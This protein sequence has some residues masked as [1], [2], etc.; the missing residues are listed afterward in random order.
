MRVIELAALPGAGKTRVCAELAAR[1][2]PGHLSWVGRHRRL[3]RR[4]Q[5]PW[6][7]LPVALLRYRSVL[8]VLRAHPSR[9]ALRDALRALPVHLAEML[10]FGLECRLRRR[11][12]ILDEGF[13]QRGIGLWLRADPDQRS[14]LWEAWLACAPREHT[15]LVLSCSPDEALR[16]ARSRPRGPS[17][18]R[19]GEV[20]ATHA[21][22]IEALLRAQ[23]L[24]PRLHCVA[25]DASGAPAEVLEATR[26][27]LEQ[28]LPAR[29]RLFFLRDELPPSRFASGLARALPASAPDAYPR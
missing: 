7:L 15:C 21:P 2:G 26:R 23:S 28:L 22:G 25:V 10:L 17:L 13:V 14:A 29:R 1:L 19:T 5:L 16:R 20:S 9:A 18:G 12:P 6:L 3:I 27:A 8:R 4:S 11:V 24:Q